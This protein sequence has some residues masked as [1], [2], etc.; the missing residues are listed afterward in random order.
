VRS[1][2][3]TPPLPA[4]SS[5]MPTAAP[6]SQALT[7][8]LALPGLDPRLLAV[9]RTAIGYSKAPATTYRMPAKSSGGMWPTPTRIAR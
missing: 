3:V 7:P 9:T 6:A 1:A 2:K 5:R 8:G 4:E